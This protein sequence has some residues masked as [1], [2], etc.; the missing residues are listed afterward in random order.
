M[1]SIPVSIRR[2][3]RVLVLGTSFVLSLGAAASCADESATVAEATLQP[4]ERMLPPAP[5]AVVEDA[6]APQLPAIDVAGRVV[7]DADEVVVGRPIVIVDHRGKRQEVLTDEDGGFYAGTVA[8]PY[9]L[10][11]EAAPS[12][13][14]ITPLVFLGLQRADPRLEVFEHQGPTERAEAQSIRIGVKLP[15]CRSVDTGC[16]VSVVTWSPRGCGGT[17]GSYVAG[18]PGAVYDVEH[19]WS[20]AV[21]PASET[22]DVHVLIGDADYTQYAYAHVDHVAA[23]PGELTDVGVVTA[24]EIGS[25]EPVSIAARTPGAPADWGWT[26]ASELELPGGAPMSLRY[27]WSASSAMR[28]PILPGATWRVAAWVQHP[29]TPDRPYFQRSAQAWSGTLPLETTNVALTV[30]AVPEPMR[31]ALEGPFSRRERALVWDGHA[32]ALASVV[33]V[34]LARSEQRF[35]VFTA[36]PDVPLRRLEALG[37]RRIDHGA[38]VLDLTTTPGATVDELTDPDESHRKDRFDLRVAGGT[39]YQRFRFTVTQ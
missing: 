14:V 2:A 18:T 23:R 37:L 27:E 32:P 11:V 31:P 9:D 8:P 26:L 4:P 3:S 39:T 1:Q 12:G 30:P 15:P 16:W 38:H 25:S 20:D 7:N 5:A 13:A 28:L 17:A 21:V 34:D 24:A 35:R 29:P 6:R 22:V 19:S 10:L 33:L 36:E